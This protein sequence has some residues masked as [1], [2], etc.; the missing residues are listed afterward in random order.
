L[1]LRRLPSWSFLAIFAGC[2][3]PSLVAL[4][5]SQVRHAPWTIQDRTFWIFV[6]GAAASLACM[7]ASRF[8]S[9]EQRERERRFF[10]QM[11]TPVDFAKEIGASRDYGQLVLLGR[12]VLVMAGLLALL[13][14]VPNEPAGRLAI[15]FVAGMT[16]AV[17]VA[18]L[19]GARLE[20]RR[21]AARS[22]AAGNPSDAAP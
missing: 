13:L 16:A 14:F 18:L 20:A 2:L 6:F 17:G 4:Y 9:P 7:A 22:A 15:L 19:V 21:D 3:A 11:K 8:S 10:T 12:T 5:D 1:W